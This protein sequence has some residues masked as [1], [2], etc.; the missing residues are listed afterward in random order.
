MH[1]LTKPVCGLQGDPMDVFKAFF[2]GG[3]P[4][5]GGGGPF[6]GGGGGQRGRGGG[7]PSNFLTLYLDLTFSCHM[8]IPCTLHGEPKVRLTYAYLIN[9]AHGDSHESWPLA[10]FI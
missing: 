2:G 4:F 7:E 3:D 9:K 5:G 8:S 10:V 1:E 6:G